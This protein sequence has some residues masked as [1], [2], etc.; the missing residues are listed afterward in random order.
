MLHPLYSRSIGLA[1]SVTRAAI[2]NEEE[3]WNAT[4]LFSWMLGVFNSAQSLAVSALGYES[5]VVAIPAMD[6]DR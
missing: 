2:G 4:L 3:G 5:I 1:I 6:A